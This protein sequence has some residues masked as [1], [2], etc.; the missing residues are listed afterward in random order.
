MVWLVLALMNDAGLGGDPPGHI[1]VFSFSS[2]LF[3]LIAFF[4]LFR[5]IFYIGITTMM[6]H[7]PAQANNSRTAMTK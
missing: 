6:R 4:F 7:H 5:P 1:G 3:K 2:V